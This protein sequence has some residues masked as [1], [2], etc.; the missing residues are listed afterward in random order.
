MVG[1][2]LLINLLDR[3]PLGGDA[4]DRIH[5]L[6]PST[7]VEGDRKRDPIVVSREID[8]MP[9][10]LLK[11]R[12][13][14]VEMPKVSEPYAGLVQGAELAAQVDP[15]QAH[16][17]PHFVVGPAPILGRESEQRNEAHAMVAE[18]LNHPA[19]IFGAGAMSSL[20]AQAALLRPAPVA[21]HDDGHV[22]WN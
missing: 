3:Y 14:H 6:A 18:A 17:R 2:H 11:S 7:V 21:V 12:I 20:A 1:E 5:D 15:R 22:R 13:E 8:G 4:L 10:F 19:D 16:Q 9:D